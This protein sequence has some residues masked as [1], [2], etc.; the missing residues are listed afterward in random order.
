MAYNGNMALSISNIGLNDSINEWFQA[1]KAGITIQSVV[2]EVMKSGKNKITKAEEK[3][4]YGYKE[5]SGSE[6]LTDKQYSKLTQ[7]RIH[8]SVDYNKDMDYDEDGEVTLD[9]KFKYY[10]VQVAKRLESLNANAPVIKKPE[11]ISEE[12]KS[13]DIETKN[14]EKNN[15]NKKDENTEAKKMSSSSTTVGSTIDNSGVKETT[16]S[17]TNSTE[18]SSTESTSESIDVKYN[19]S[20]VNK[21]KAA[22]FN[23]SLVDNSILAL[24]A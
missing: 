7:K 6:K 13:Q 16:E 11:K 14:T 24:S 3:T 21:V 8:I 4:A 17:V 2:D 19:V 12:I 1:K 15:I 9:E 18:G 10:A 5:D 22:Y 23:D 20:Q